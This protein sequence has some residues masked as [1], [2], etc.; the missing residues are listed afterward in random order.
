[1]AAQRWRTAAIEMQAAAKTTEAEPPPIEWL[2]G[3]V[4]ALVFGFVDAKTL[5]VTIPSVCTAWRQ[6]CSELVTQIQLDFGW[7]TTGPTNDPRNPLMDAGLSGFTL[8]GFKT[9]RSVN[10]VGCRKVTDVGLTS[11]GEGCPNLETLNVSWCN[12]ITD[13]GLA[14]IGEGCPNLE[15]LYLNKCVQITDAGLATIGEGCRVSRSRSIC[16]RGPWRSRRI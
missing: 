9:V 4:V 16:R 10:L 11:V 2:P 7:A 13:A 8:G 3:E 12:H 1:M 15:S 5:M 6:V 14:R